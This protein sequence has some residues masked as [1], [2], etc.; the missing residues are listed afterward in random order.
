MDVKQY[1][2]FVVIFGI[3]LCSKMSKMTEL[4]HNFT[5]D[6]NKYIRPGLDDNNPQVVN[7]TFNL[8]ALRK[9]NEIE[10]YISTVQFFYI[11]WIDKRISW[12]PLQNENIAQLSFRSDNV[13][14]PELVI[15]NPAD[16]I[17]AFDETPSTVRYSHDGLAVWRPG[18]VSKTLCDIETPAYPFDVHTCYLDII[19]WDSSPSEIILGSPL[20][21]A[22]TA[23]YARNAE[24]SLTGTKAFAFQSYGI[25]HVTVALQFSR[26]SAFLVMNIVTPIVFLDL[27]NPVVFLLPHESGERITFSVTILLSFTVFLNVIGD[28]VPKTSSPMPLL[29]HYVVIVLVTSGIITVLITLCQRL[30]HSRGHEP[31]P[32]LLQDILRMKSPCTRNDVDNLTSENNEQFSSDEKRAVIHDTPIL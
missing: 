31:I 25:A 20:N 12:D 14:T 24:W 7:V 16:T 30:Y 4:I 11:M 32:K 17:H 22:M 8:V 1:L 28:N 26:N 13:W 10:G 18:M 21:A 3:G 5:T 23:F 9:I 29:S 2:I 27:L 15:S 19:L 6:Y